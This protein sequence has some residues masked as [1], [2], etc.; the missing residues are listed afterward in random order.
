MQLPFALLTNGGGIL[1]S[2]RAEYVNNIVF[3]GQPLD[4]QVIAAE[5]MILCHTPFRDLRSLYHD[6]HILVTGIGSI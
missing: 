5:R 1:E 2:K 4:Q 6:Q 3:G